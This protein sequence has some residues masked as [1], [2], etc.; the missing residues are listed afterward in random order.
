MTTLYTTKIVN[1]VINRNNE[2]LFILVNGAINNTLY[3]A[4]RGNM[5]YANLE[6]YN[7]TATQWVKATSSAEAKRCIYF[8]YSNLSSRIKRRCN[9][10]SNA[11]YQYR[12]GNNIN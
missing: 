5:I 2:H 9:E 1:S 8:S 11:T 3:S 7:V 4:E 6:S 10:I 12:V